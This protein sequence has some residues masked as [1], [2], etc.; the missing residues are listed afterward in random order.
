MKI[1]MSALDQAALHVLDA[2][3]RQCR[4]HRCQRVPLTDVMWPAFLIFVACK[5]AMAALLSAEVAIVASLPIVMVE[6]KAPASD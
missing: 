2:E 5:V 4:S 6:A 1:P 3:S